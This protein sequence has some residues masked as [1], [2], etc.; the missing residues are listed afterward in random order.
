MYNN[1]GDVNFNGKFR[2]IPISAKQISSTLIEI[3]VDNNLIPFKKGQTNRVVKLL[4]S[5]INNKLN[6]DAK[7]KGKNN[8]AIKKFVLSLELEFENFKSMPVKKKATKKAVT[9][10]AA[11]SRKKVTVKK[12]VAP[13]KK[14]VRRNIEI[15]S[16]RPALP[17]GKRISKN[18]AVYYEYRENH[19]DN[20]QTKKKGQMLGI[21]NIRLTRIT[22]DTNGN[23]R[24][25]V[26]FLELLN[27]EENEFLDFSKKYDYAL[28]KA[29]KIGGR[30]FHNK[31]YGGGIV[32]Q[33][34]NTDDLKQDIMDIQNS[35]I[36]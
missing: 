34:Y 7:Q 1:L 23:P 27:N 31:Q 32:F 35:N 5:I 3:N 2:G 21:N 15:D 13:R 12:V 16:N 14:I 8:T 20:K 10:K 36:K 18:G 25:V 29:K 4:Q 26:H 19:A 6:D 22:N 33:S 28:K 30:K 24:Y 11:A 9:K 17:K